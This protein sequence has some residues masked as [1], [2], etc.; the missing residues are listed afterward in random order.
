[1][2]IGIMGGTFDPIHNAHLI[3]A[4]YAAEQYGID[5]L[6][7]MT[8]G[9]PPHKSDVTDKYIRN[10]M[11]EIAVNGEFEVNTYE[12]DKEE[13][14]YSLHTLQHFKEEYPNDD[15]YFIIGEDSLGDINK[16]YKPQEI[17]KLCKLL[18]FPRISFESLKE[19]ILT[20]KKTLEGEIYPI[21]APIIGLS[22]TIIR[23]RLSQGKSVRNMI[24]DKVLDYIK[25]NG[26]YEN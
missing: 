11:T 3:I 16:W 2:K 10:H 26:L 1:M 12:I 23:E 22:S 24:P 21:N 6:M 5:R 15:I 20:T 8:G 9:N 25:E 4:R 14:S 7:F 17:L 18:V 13:Y 19:Q